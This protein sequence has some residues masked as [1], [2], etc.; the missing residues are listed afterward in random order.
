MKVITIENRDIVLTTQ[1]VREISS[2]RSPTRPG[3]NGTILRAGSRVSFSSRRPKASSLKSFK[4]RWTLPS[5]PTVRRDG[6][7][8]GA[9]DHA[10]WKPSAAR[11]ASR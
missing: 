7:E 4:P 10:G 5:K 9:A 8:G 3:S 6:R 2:R 1:T 11:Q